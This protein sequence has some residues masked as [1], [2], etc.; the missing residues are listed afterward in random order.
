M[1]RGKEL[2]SDLRKII[3]YNFESGKSAFICAE[4]LNISINTVKKI[5]LKYK[6]SKI[7]SVQQR[8]GRPKK[9]TNR[10]QRTLERLVRHN[11]RCTAAELSEKFS[12][13][14]QKPVS[15]STTIRHLHDI[16]YGYFKVK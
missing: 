9:I 3:I 12:N 13:A 5:Y 10:D 16:S 7:E 1:S 15:V 6:R 8:S 14:I 11:R 4:E 2:S